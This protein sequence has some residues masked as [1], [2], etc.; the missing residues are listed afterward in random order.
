M[1]TRCGSGCGRSACWRSTAPG[2]RPRRSA[3][4]RTSAPSWWPSWA[5]S[6]ATT[7]P[8]WSTPSSPRIPRSIFRSRPKPAPAR[9]PTPRLLRPLP[10]HAPGCPVST[11]RARSWA[12][13]ASR[14]CCGN[15]G[16]R[17]ATA[18]GASSSSTET[19]GSERHASS[20]NCGARWRR[21]RGSGCG[22][23]ATRTTSHPSSPLPRLSAGTSNCPRP[24]GS[25]T[26]RTGNSRSCP[27]SCLACV[28]T[29]LRSRRIAATPR[30]AASDSSKPSRPR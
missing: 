16:P 18:A 15:G 9:R 28:S 25:H 13:N 27:G 7:S 10:A 8:G 4:S 23:V 1:L 2:G 30:A 26:C 14:R 12:A 3:S 19:L 29:R 24:T 17:S 20:S 5:L 22:G 21:T 11:T 6:R